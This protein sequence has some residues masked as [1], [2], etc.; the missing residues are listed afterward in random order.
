MSK[1]P[2]PPSAGKLARITP[3][4]RVLPR[5][6]VLWR[7]YFRG[8]RHPTFWNT[9]RSFGPTS[10]RF[11]HQ[12]PPA[13]DQERSIF[14][15]ADLG[16]A[17]IAEVFQD[18]RV[19]DRL[20]R[21]PWLVGF[22]LQVP[23][24]L[25][26]LTGS[27]P[28]RAWASMVIGSGPRPR[29]QRWSKAIYEAYPDGQGVYYASSMYRNSP[30]MALYERAAAALPPNPVFHRA[31]GDPALLPVLKRVARDIGYGLV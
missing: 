24:V 25:L 4:W 16:P 14:Y 21:D 31:L 12:I 30:S 1:F 2:E 5:K 22:S 19:I 11:D 27:W 23:V 26:D 9:F 28:T 8:G 15:T 3:D 20:A 13:H 18:T 6:A 10:G 7:L 17:C 29:A